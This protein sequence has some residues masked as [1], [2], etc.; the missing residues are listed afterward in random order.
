VK[1]FQAVDLESRNGVL[2]QLRARRRHS[3]PGHINGWEVARRARQIDQ[4]LPVIYMT[5]CYDGEEWS[6]QGVPD[7]TLVQKRFAPAQLPTPVSQLVNT[8]RPALSN[9][10]KGWMLSSVTRNDRRHLR[11][12]H[13]LSEGHMPHEQTW[14][15]AFK[16]AERWRE[17]G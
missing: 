13:L 9:C 3:S 11:V 1:N 15:I 5:G 2:P 10:A 17:R 14:R 16:A 6:S 12:A 8:G 7:H 4:L